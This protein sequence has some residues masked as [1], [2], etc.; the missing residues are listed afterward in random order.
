MLW[1]SFL[2][3]QEAPG[4]SVCSAGKLAVETLLAAWTLWMHGDPTLLNNNGNG[5]LKCKGP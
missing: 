4:E 2:E 3:A 5:N 1:L